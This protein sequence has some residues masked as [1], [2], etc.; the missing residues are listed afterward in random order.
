MPSDLS[1]RILDAVSSL[2]TAPLTRSVTISIGIAA[3]PAH[4][5]TAEDLIKK[6][7]LALYQSK[8]NGKNRVSVYE[9]SLP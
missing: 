5:A 7:D 8:K 4:A 2:V 1:E 9:P 6:A 3:F